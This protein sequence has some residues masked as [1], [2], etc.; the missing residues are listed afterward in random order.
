MLNHTT[1]KEVCIAYVTIN[2]SMGMRVG[3]PNISLL[4]A[5]DLEWNVGLGGNDMNIHHF[6]EDAETLK[7]GFHYPSS[8][9]E[10]TE[11]ELGPWTRAVNSG[12]GNRPLV[13]VRGSAARSVWLMGVV[14][15]V[16]RSQWLT[17]IDKQRSPN[18]PMWRY[19]Q[20]NDRYNNLGHLLQSNTV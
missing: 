4:I 2:V 8:R 3:G 5:R 14:Y 20:I 15:Y 9:P 13:N 12:N 19:R 16:N 7:V 10:F 18:M 11:R 1:I 17:P 6:P